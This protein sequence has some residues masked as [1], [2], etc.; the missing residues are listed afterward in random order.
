MMAAIQL[1]RFGAD[2]LLFECGPLGG[3]LLHAYRL[4]NIPGFP[5]GISGPDLAARMVEQMKRF[6]VSVIPERVVRLAFTRGAF[7]LRTARR[8]YCADRVIIASGTCPKSYP[9]ALRGTKA[10]RQRLF[11]SVLPLRGRRGMRMAVI[12]AS[13]AAC[14]YALSLAVHNRVWV[15]GRSDRLGAIAPLAGAVE[16]HPRISIIR[17]VAVRSLSMRRG[18]LHITGECG[19]TPYALDVDAAVTAIGREPETRFIAPGL[20]SRLASLQSDGRLRLIGD[21][22]RGRMRQASIAAGDGMRAAME[23]WEKR[24]EPQ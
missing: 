3:L 10:V 12:G 23:L 7:H 1:Q 5:E 17:N 19:R 9:I 18:M 16:S 2:L 15:L 22:V 13:D 14:D 4:D 24:K 11:D 20:M 6:K 21:V 8:S